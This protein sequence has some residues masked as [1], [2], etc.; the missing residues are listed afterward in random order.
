M[1]KVAIFKNTP[2]SV[3]AINEFIEN[4]VLIGDGPA[5]GNET[6]VFT[7][8]VPGDVGMDDR[9][10]TNGLSNELAKAQRR[11]ADLFQK[12][13]ETQ[14]KINTFPED[15]SQEQRGGLVDGL[16]QLENAYDDVLLSITTIFDF[17]KLSESGEW[18][19]PQYN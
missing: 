6:I 18:K 7:Y 14:K 16:K 2:E 13:L 10:V 4:N 15:G 9:G 3:P 19:L 1:M 5:I 11:L 12:I 17:M 8:R